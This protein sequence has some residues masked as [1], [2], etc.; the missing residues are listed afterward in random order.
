MEALRI[1]CMGKVQGVFFRVSAKNK[2]DELGVKGWV[3]NVPDGSVEIQAEGDIENLELLVEWCRKGP[4]F[5]KVVE[6]IFESV[7]KE[8]H[9]SFE[10][11]HF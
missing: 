10:I 1:V 2:A 6:V 4:Q 11:K 3:R 8:D 9:S 5:A 7:Q